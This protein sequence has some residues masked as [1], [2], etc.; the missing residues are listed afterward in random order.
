MPLRQ[1]GRAKQQRP[2]CANPILGTGQQTVVVDL[3]RVWLH[4]MTVSKMVPRA[5]ASGSGG[6]A[7]PNVS[8]R[9]QPA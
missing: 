4:S 8:V 1:C 3:Q 5:F 2:A 7:H 6:D 9:Q